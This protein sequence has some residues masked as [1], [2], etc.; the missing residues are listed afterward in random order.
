MKKVVTSCIIALSIGMAI[1]LVLYKLFHRNY[2]E[3]LASESA[4]L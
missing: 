3:S 1:G 2:V 4:D